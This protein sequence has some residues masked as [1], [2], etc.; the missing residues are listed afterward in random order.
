MP[1][2]FE[3]LK[4]RWPETALIVGLALFGSVGLELMGP[5][6]YAE[7]SAAGVVILIGTIIFYVVQMMLH[8]GFVRTAYLEGDRPQEPMVLLRT[9]RRF[10]WRL[11]L[12]SMMYAGMYLALGFVIF[13]IIKAAGFIKVGFME[14]EIWSRNLCFVVSSL[15]LVKFI[16]LPPALIIVRDCGLIASIR[17]IRQFKILSAR[18]PLVL[19]AALQAVTYFAAILA[20]I[21]KTETSGYYVYTI[22]FSLLSAL[23]TLAIS[24]STVRFAAMSQPQY[25]IVNLE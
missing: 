11:F 20:P 10:F 23:I 15:I 25:K 5:S 4:R 21:D 1:K 19:F 7:P 9:G 14:A 8:L 12:F 3:I 24:V 16:L 17:A 22:I 2:T 13:N 6:S 18:E